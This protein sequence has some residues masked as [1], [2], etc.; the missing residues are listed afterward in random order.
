[1]L[2]GSDG[3]EERARRMLNW[4]VSNGVARRAWSG[5]DNAQSTIKR[6]MEADH[7]LKITVANKVENKNLIDELKFWFL[8][9]SNLY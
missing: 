2:D 5:N 6:A 1:M 9:K 4:D 3:A 8:Q 7:K